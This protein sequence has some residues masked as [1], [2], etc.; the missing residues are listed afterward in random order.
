MVLILELIRTLVPD[1]T[2]NIATISLPTRIRDFDS[3]FSIFLFTYS[4][5]I[6]ISLRGPRS[7]NIRY[8]PDI[9]LMIS[10][11]NIGRQLFHRAKPRLELCADPRIF[12]SLFVKRE[13]RIDSGSLQYRRV[14]WSLANPSRWEMNGSDPGVIRQLTEIV[15]ATR[16][17]RS[18]PAH[19]C[20]I[21]TRPS[22]VPSPSADSFFSPFVGLFLGWNRLISHRP[23]TYFSVRLPNSNE[24]AN[25]IAEIIRLS[26]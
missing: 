19:P 14:V 22:R 7:H 1:T 25:G 21:H 11:Q 15:I 6:L 4:P 13:E 10:I 23:P 17:P 2:C 24:A 26:A 9:T 20:N 12:V 8:H 3:T 18:D 5:F 16:Q